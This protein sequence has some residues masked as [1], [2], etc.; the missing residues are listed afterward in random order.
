MKSPTFSL[1][2]PWRS[3]VVNGD[4]K[5]GVDLIKKHT[6]VYRL[7][8][9]DNPPAMKFVNVSGRDFG[10][11]APADYAFWEL[12]NQVVQ[13]EPSESLDPIRLGFYA[14]IGIE[15][16][17]PFAPDARMKKILTDAAL[18]GDERPGR[19]PSTRAR[20]RH[21]I[22]RT[23]TG[24]CPS[25]AATGSRHSPMSSTWMPTSIIISWRPA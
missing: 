19:L 11:V 15:K 13:E 21:S 9:A 14:S 6:R 22:T 1:W 10:T 24:S 16:G 2:A 18:V 25:S 12:L 3:F 5:P 7:S 20:R 4:P 23:A 8:E 17:K